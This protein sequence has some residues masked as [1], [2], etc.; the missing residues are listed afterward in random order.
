MK[1]ILV[2]VDGSAAGAKGVAAAIE[3]ARGLEARLEL[4]TVLP[5]ILLP[6]AA[7]ADTI[8]KLERGNQEAAQ[9]LLD[10]AAKPVLEAG[11]SCDTVRLHGAPAE[12]IAELAQAERVWGVVVGAKGHTALGRVLVGSVADR[13]VHICPKHVLVVR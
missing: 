12:A 8:E 1:S 9:A 11:V 13:L 4:V 2:A 6:A 5:P 3:L 10:K 7:Y